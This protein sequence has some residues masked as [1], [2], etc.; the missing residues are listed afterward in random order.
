M[1][2]LLKGLVIL[3]FALLIACSQVT[4]ENF[5]KIQP[6][7]SKEQV[8]NLLGKPT[9]M[10]SISIGGLSGTSATWD[11]K[12]GLVTIIFINDK[13]QLKSLSQANEDNQPTLISPATPPKPT[14]KQPGN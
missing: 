14:P 2:A 6:G 5:D 12:V 13:V 8:I 1:K 4:Q 11:S 3:C 10:A 7:M 9:K